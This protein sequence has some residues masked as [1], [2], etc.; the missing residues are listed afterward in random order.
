MYTQK[1]FE[2]ILTEN[3]TRDGITVLLN[4]I[5]KTDFFTAPASTRYHD[6]CEGGL[7]HHSVKV[8]YK[9]RELLEHKPDIYNQESVAII[10]LLHDLC[11]MG[12][13]KVEMRNTKN[14]LGKWIQVPYYTVDDKFPMGHGEK[15]VILIMEHLK[16]TTDEQ[17]SIRWHMGGFE[18]KENHQT[19]SK[20]Y[21]QCNLAMYLHLADMLAT[22]EK[23][24]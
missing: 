1:D 21:E 20:A 14:E 13:Y 5:R 19:L 4:A 6:S 12:F 3:V 7:V 18:A 16:L 17:F 15:S 8:Y 9:L 2:S 10:A 24:S 23:D 22:F 11:K